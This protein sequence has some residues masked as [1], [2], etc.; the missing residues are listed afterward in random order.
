[1]KGSKSYNDSKNDFKYGRA[2]QP[3]LSCLKWA[4]RLT[5][6]YSEFEHAANH[7]FTRISSFTKFLPCWVKLVRVLTKNNHTYR[8]HFVLWIGRTTVG[9]KLGIIM[10][11]KNVYSKL[12]LLYKK[13]RFKRYLI[14]KINFEIWILSLFK[15][16]LLCV[17]PFM[18]K[19][20]TNFEPP[21]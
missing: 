17:F 1:M 13:E 4:F 15:V 11:F 5:I 2:V 3:A 16:P 10:C 6:K 9:P 14:L 20:L 12:M 19:T 7:T 8:T 21:K 18:A